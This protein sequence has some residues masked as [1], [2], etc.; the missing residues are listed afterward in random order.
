VNV[1]IRPT[2]VRPYAGDTVQT[3]RGL[4]IIRSFKSSSSCRVFLIESGTVATADI[5]VMRPAGRLQKA[6]AAAWQAAYNLS[7][8][9]TV[10]GREWAAWFRDAAESSRDARNATIFGGFLVSATAAFATVSIF[11]L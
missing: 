8:M 2:H 5:V 9:A 11:S 10:Q 6:R 7:G 3:D 1:Y 4:G